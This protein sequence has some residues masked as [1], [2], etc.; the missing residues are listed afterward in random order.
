MIVILPRKHC[1]NY[2]FIE[3]FA[4]EPRATPK[5]YLVLNLAYRCTRLAKANS[6]LAKANSIFH[7]IPLL[8]SISCN[9]SVARPVQTASCLWDRTISHATHLVHLRANRSM[10]PER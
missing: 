4:R 5:V 8:P 3:R 2:P 1:E 9:S 6:I 7:Q 10:V